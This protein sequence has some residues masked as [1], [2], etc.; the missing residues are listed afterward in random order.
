MVGDAANLPH[1][2]RLPSPSFVSRNAGIRLS[3][4][5]FDQRG[6]WNAGVRNNWLSADTSF[7]DAGEHGGTTDGWWAGVTCGDV[8]LERGNPD[9]NTSAWL[10]RL[11]WIY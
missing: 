10:Y 3:N 5:M 6:T 1:T 11:Q 7:D 2:E 9:G 8:G 4:T